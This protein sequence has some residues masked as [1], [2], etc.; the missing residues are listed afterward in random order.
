MMYRSWSYAIFLV[1]AVFDFA[2]APPAGA[3]SPQRIG[4]DINQPTLSRALLDY[5]AQS[6]IVVTVRPELVEGKP[7]PAV[8]G[9]MTPDEALEKLLRGSGLRSRKGPE[10]EITID[11]PRPGDTKAV[12]P[13]VNQKRAGLETEFEEITVTAQRRAESI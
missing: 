9:E 3:Q 11:G 10:G 2:L 7:A 13:Y 4:F 8:K 1:W 5:S 6:H 12:S